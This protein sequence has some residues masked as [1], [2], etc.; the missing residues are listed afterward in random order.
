MII[1]DLQKNYTVNI[2]HSLIEQKNRL[3]I[4]LNTK[5][6]LRR[7]DLQT[8]DTEWYKSEIGMYFNIFI[9]F[10]EA[11]GINIHIL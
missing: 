6:L 7:Q 10:L 3:V 8:S 2:L 9:L 11:I 4:E 5:L 1:K